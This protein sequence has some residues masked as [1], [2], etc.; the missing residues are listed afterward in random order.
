MS[1]RNVGIHLQYYM[2]SQPTTIRTPSNKVQILEDRM[3][4]TDDTPSPTRNDLM[5]YNQAVYI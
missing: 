5:V 4:R 1:L 2:V 3:P